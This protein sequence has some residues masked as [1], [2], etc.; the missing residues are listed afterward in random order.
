MNNMRAHIYRAERL[1][2]QYLNPWGSDSSLIKYTADTAQKRSPN[3]VWGVGT[4]EER[5]F[6]TL[7]SINHLPML[8]NLETLVDLIY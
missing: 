2:P 1:S 7:A 6:G 4:R 8:T 3:S 5:A